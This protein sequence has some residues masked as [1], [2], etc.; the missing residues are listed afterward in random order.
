MIANYHTHTWRCKH[1]TG[2]EREYIEQAIL[3]GYKIFGFSDHIPIPYEGDYVSKDKMNL[4]Q[5]EDY[6]DTVLQLKKEYQNDIQIHLGLEV[7]YYPKYFEEMM[8]FLEPYPIEYFILGQHYINNEIGEVY[9]ARPTG[10]PAKLEQYCLQCKDAMDLGCFTYFAHPDLLNFTGD[11]GF[12]EKCM[13]G[14]C[15]H[16]KF[17]DIPLELNFLGIWKQRNYPNPF[18]WK[19]A[20][21]TGNR[22]VYGADAHMTD[23]VWNPQALAI[24][25]EMAERYHL[26]V[27][28]TVE[29]QKIR[30]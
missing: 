26:N 24:A 7:E 1:A 17:R 20:G 25:E 21:E 29:L 28:D 9:N 8:H 2:T 6:V 30:K 12:Y 13:R 19:I 4:D 22:V 5:M 16:A 3:G 11:L 27:I 15:E 18:F 23:K 14:L 10:D